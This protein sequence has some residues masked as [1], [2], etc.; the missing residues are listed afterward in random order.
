M[1]AS[2]KATALGLDRVSFILHG[3]NLADPSLP[4]AGLGMCDR[5]RTPYLFR[6]GGIEKE[7][8]KLDLKFPEGRLGLLDRRG[9]SFGP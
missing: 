5:L 1:T 2:L 8:G 7:A 3:M 4:L 6:W 9:S